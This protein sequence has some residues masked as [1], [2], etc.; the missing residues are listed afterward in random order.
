MMRSLMAG[1]A[2][3][4]FVSLFPTTVSAQSRAQHCN[5]WHSRCLATCPNGPGTCAPICNQRKAACMSSGCYFFNSPG[6]RCQ[7]ASR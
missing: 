6:P 3:L 5:M 2:L 4:A 7:S 1:L